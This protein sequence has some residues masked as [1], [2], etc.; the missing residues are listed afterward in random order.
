[1]LL[2]DRTI[3]IIIK[4]DIDY[5]TMQF[6]T[7]KKNILVVEG[8]N[9]KEML[10]LIANRYDIEFDFQIVEMK[11]VANIFKLKDAFDFHEDLNVK[12][13]TDNDSAARRWINSNGISRDEVITNIVYSRVKPSIKELE[14]FITNTA[15]WKHKPTKK[16]LIQRIWNWKNVSEANVNHLLTV[17]NNCFR[18]RLKI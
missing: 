4:E 5:G 11:G 1:M 6:E 16:K 14:E 18:P 17:L 12:F 10:E 13:L 3:D 7:E 2:T 15:H 8:K 9:D